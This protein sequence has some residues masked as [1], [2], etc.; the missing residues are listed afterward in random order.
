MSDRPTVW[1]TRPQP[2][3]DRTAATLAVAGYDP[4]LLPLTEIR[5][6]DP[7]LHAD[8]LRAFDAVAVTS[9]NALRHAPDGLVAALRG[10]PLYAVG[11]A[12]ASEAEARGFSRAMSA[13]GAVDDLADLIAERE[14]PGAAIL[15]LC[16]RTRTGDL[17][18]KLAGKGFRASPAETY[19]TDIV[20]H[21]T[22]Y[23]H[24]A[25]NRRAPRAVLF[26]SR[27]AAQT[28]AERILPIFPQDFDK[29]AFLAMSPRV[30]E[31][32]PVA[33]QAQIAVAGEP[34]EP[35]LLATLRATL[36]AAGTDLPG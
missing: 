36:P 33:L 10:T 5:A 16:G 32:L 6:L 29:T 9:A 3:A 20:S 25:L 11:D 34:T 31:A 30:A 24:N 19:S 27:L 35:S 21:P 7:G 4:F 13:R 8:E 18:G 23:L 15:Y 14:R 26:H 2:G 1:I 28:F 17:E 12:T 22:E